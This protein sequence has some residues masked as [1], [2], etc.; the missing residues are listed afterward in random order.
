MRRSMVLLLTPSR[1]AICV[2]GDPDQ[3]VV[4]QRL[5]VEFPQLAERDQR[6]QVVDQSLDYSSLLVAVCVSVS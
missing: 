4:D 5:S 6:V 1:S 3:G 2:Q